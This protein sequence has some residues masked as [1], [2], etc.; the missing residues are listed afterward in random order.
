[1]V[2]TAISIAFWLSTCLTVIIL[3]LPSQYIPRRAKEGENHND[4]EKVTVQILVLGDIGRS[5]RMQYHALSIARHGG[6]VDIIGYQGDQHPLVRISNW[7]EKLFCG[8][9]TAHLCV[10]NA[11]ARVLKE[12]FGISKAPIL[13]LHDRPASHFKAILDEEERVQFL[14]SL[15][16][17]TATK[18]KL[19]SGD[20]R[21]LV[22]STSWTPDEDFLVLIDALC[23]Y[24]EVATAE[25]TTLPRVL[26]I[27][28]GKGPQK[29]M[30]LNEISSREKAGK[31][32]KVTI[33]TAWLST[34]DY[35]R[36]LGCASLGVSLHTSSS[37]VDLPMKVV[38]MFGAGLPV[39]GWSRFEAWPE[40]VT[41]GVNGRGF[42]SSEELASHLTDLFGNPKKL[43][44]LRNG[45]QKESL[46]RWDQEWDPIAGRL[47]E[48]VKP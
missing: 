32:E 29:E 45:A 47:L 13:T 20:V 27:I 39:V 48:L 19:A 26:A 15:E 22:S 23:R 44:N 33:K 9:A 12:E 8:W 1:M 18:A 14:A 30:Y 46:R 6:L 35:A 43:E 34:L 36:L 11:M 2:E 31:L 40:L 5:P 21:V 24:S 16:E 7:Y 41:E 4:Q 17:V 10:T 3:A 37:G 28:T 25:N 38:D 42:G